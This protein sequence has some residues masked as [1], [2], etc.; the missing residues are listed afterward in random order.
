MIEL[1]EKPLEGY[2]CQF[3][4]GRKLPEGN[5]YSAISGLWD[6]FMETTE[7]CRNML[8]YKDHLSSLQYIFYSCV[9]SVN[10]NYVNIVLSI[11]NSNFLNIWLF[12]LSGTLLIVYLYVL[13]IL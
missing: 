4:T 10:L 5:R 13:E 11:G 3:G 9:Q 12:L 8:W 2:V 7:L 6:E 1:A